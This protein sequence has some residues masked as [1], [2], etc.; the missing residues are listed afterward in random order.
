MSW[1][2]QLLPSISTTQPVLIAGPTASGKSA[3]AMALAQRDG[4]IIVNADALQV[5]ARWRTLTARPSPEDEAAAPHRLYGHVGRDVSYS[6][7]KW[8]DDVAAVLSLGKPI[9][10]VG[11]SGLN[12]TALT[13]GLADIPISPPEIRALA[14][15][16]KAAEGI[17]ALLAELDPATR[18]RIDPANPARVQRAWEVLKFT[19]RGLADWHNT[20]PPA[21]IPLADADCIALRPDVDWLNERIDRRFDQMI[22]A[23]ALDEVAAELPY[24]VPNQPSSQAIGAAELVGYLRGEI[25]LKDAVHA[26]K[27]ASRQYAKRQRTWLRSKM[28][29][30]RGISLP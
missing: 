18:A 25:L 22:A 14:D 1:V 20:T 13:I 10:I 30:W 8:L 7:G 9:V 23:G 28:G 5:Y 3:L 4:R 11:G 29:G 12:L 27:L 17:G 2:K 19:G 24:W 6:V 21:L 26:S 15:S 16:R